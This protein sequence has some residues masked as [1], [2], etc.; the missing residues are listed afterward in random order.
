MSTKPEYRHHTERKPG[1]SLSELIEAEHPEMLN[2]YWQ[3]MDGELS[4]IPDDVMA[5]GREWV[6]CVR[7]E[8]R[9]VR[10]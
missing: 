3:W 9:E 1:M 5:L 8:T 2:L 4:E 10:P 7:Q 6:Q